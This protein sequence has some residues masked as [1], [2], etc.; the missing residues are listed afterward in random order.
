MKIHKKNTSLHTLVLMR[1]ETGPN[2]QI[3]RRAKL[4]SFNINQEKN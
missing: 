3:L 2:L 1:A 4:S